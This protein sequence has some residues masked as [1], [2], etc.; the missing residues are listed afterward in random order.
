MRSKF[1]AASW[2]GALHYEEHN[3][4][5]L[6]GSDDDLDTLL[7]AQGIVWGES[8]HGSFLCSCAMIPR[9]ENTASI[10]PFQ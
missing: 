7:L 8:N 9:Y 3:R 6:L 5:F 1:G 10:Y 2:D 4:S